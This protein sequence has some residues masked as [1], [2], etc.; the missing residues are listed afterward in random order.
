[1]LTPSH[2]FAFI[3]LAFWLLSNWA[4]AHGHLCFDGQ[5]PPVSVQMSVMNGHLEHHADELHQDV[6]VDLVQSILAQ[7]S[8]KISKIDWALGLI[9]AL[10]LVLLI[11]PRAAF[12]CA[13][14]AFYPPI[15]LHWRPL[16]RAPPV[17]V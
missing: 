17:A 15:S 5:E 13:Y 10:S 2:Q 7:S 12:I 4:G 9:A 6:D 16:L 1:M 8:A 11:L 3:A 14:R